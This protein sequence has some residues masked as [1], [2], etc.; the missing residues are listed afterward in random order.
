M[1]SSTTSDR[2]GTDHVVV[3]SIW[4]FGTD[5]PSHLGVFVRQVGKV[6]IFVCAE[7]VSQV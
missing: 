7:D 6:G 3:D 1:L 2:E 5:I 4:I